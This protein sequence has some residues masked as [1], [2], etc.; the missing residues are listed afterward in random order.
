MREG[1][2]GCAVLSMVLHYV[3]RPAMAIEECGRVVRK[4]GLL[5]VADIGSHNIESLRH[6]YGHR[7]LGF[8]TNMVESWIES[9]GF[10]TEEVKRLKGAMGLNIN[11]FRGVKI[12]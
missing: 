11:I 7:W 9:A 1:E 6:D 2:A 12:H 10:K 4:G 3:D 8:D 5:L